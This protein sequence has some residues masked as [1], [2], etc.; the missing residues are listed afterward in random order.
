M[1]AVP[2]PHQITSS[3]GVAVRHSVSQKAAVEVQMF[4]AVAYRCVAEL[5]VEVS[6][7]VFLTVEH[8]VLSGVFVAASYLRFLVCVGV[9][10][11]ALARGLG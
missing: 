1:I 2:T 4:A 8:A 10:P 11:S 3:A 6:L 7:F 9:A 5:R